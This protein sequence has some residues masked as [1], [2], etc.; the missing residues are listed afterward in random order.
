MALVCGM[1]MA[2]AMHA[3]PEGSTASHHVCSICSTAHAGLSMQ[4]PAITP[5]MVAAVLV[6]PAPESAGIFRPSTTQFIRP[7]PA[8]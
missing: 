1:G 5:V 4:A 8:F 6:S 2:Q 3:H 7:P